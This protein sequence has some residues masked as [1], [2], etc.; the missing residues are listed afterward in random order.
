VV[1]FWA[2]SPFSFKHD[3]VLAALSKAASENS[4]LLSYLDLR[5]GLELEK[6][7]AEIV[8]LQWK[9]KV[10]DMQ[11]EDKDMEVERYRN[12]GQVNGVSAGHAYFGAG[13][14]WRK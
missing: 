6:R 2:L 13:L 1:Q 9:L 8:R 14:F 3:K 4:V 7:H 12:K 10:M 11:L 5:I